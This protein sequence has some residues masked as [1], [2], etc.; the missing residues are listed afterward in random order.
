MIPCYF[1]ATSSALLAD[2][3]VKLTAS[4]TGQQ[5]SRRP[6]STMELISTFQRVMVA[7]NTDGQVKTYTSPEQDVGRGPPADRET[8]LGGPPVLQA[9]G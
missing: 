3:S 7:R 4:I 1:I 8:I 6:P 2:V 5:S 9:R